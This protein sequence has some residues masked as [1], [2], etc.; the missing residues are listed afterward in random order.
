MNSKR[1]IKVGEKNLPAIQARLDTIQGKAWTR[2]YDAKGVAQV[3]EL[4]ESKLAEAGVPKARRVGR[5]AIG[6]S[7][8]GPTAQ[9]AG[10]FGFTV[11]RVTLERRYQGWYLVDTE[12]GYQLPTYAQFT[13]KIVRDWPIISEKSSPSVAQRSR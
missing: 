4:A 11:T 10:V 7:Y 9:G 13:R 1:A 3:A 2:I 8:T 5:T 12:R 6:Q